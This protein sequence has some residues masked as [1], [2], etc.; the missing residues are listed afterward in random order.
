M[1]KRECPCLLVLLAIVFLIL[2]LLVFAPPVLS[3]SEC[4]SGYSRAPLTASHPDLC[5]P[6][7]PNC[8]RGSKI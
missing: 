6:S 2:M 5:G 1:L 8:C 7:L 3:Q 4:D